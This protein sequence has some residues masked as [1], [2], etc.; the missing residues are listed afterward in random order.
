MKRRDFIKFVSA[1]SA[2]L[3]VSPRAFAYHDE[4]AKWDSYRITYQVDLPD[5]PGTARLWLPLPEIQD[6]HHQRSMG[7][8]WTGNPDEAGIQALAGG[9]VSVFY[10]EWLGNSAPSVTV[11]TIVK[12]TNRAVDLSRISSRPGAAIPNEVKRYLKASH[13][14]PTD[15]IVRATALSATKGAHTPLAKARAI[16]EWVVDNTYREATVKGCGR[17]DIKFMLETGNMGGKCADINAL[18]VGL[19]RAVGIPA[20][21]QYGIRVDDSHLFKSLGKYGDISKAQHCRA[22][23]YLAE[24]GWVPVDPADVRKVVLEENLALSDPRVVALRRRLFGS[25]EMNWIAFN[26][27]EDIVLEHGSVADKLPFF[28]YPHAEIGKE[29]QDSLDPPKFVY[30]I[31]SAEL[32]GTGVK[33]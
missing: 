21:D 13:H 19:C 29:Q 23:F 15:G 3:S 10:A 5:A 17:G 11:S 2:M 20:R 18:F 30:K 24:V 6:T 26:H 14:L 27:G 12:T 25:W 32:V 31:L 28:M 7:S 9:A 1:G 22:E 8:V 4:M 16:Y 33:L